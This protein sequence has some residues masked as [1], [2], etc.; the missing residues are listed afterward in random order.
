MVIRLGIWGSSNYQGSPGF[1]CVYCGK[2]FVHQPSLIRHRRKCE[3]NYYLSCPH[4]DRRFH[5]RDRYQEHLQKLLGSDMAIHLGIW[6]SSNYQGSPGFPCVYC[7]KTFV[8]QPSLIRH[9]RKC[10]GNYYLSCPHC[11][12]RF[13]R[14]DSYQEHLQM[15]YA[16]YA[17]L[18]RFM[19]VRC[20]RS[21]VHRTNLCRHR[22]KCEGNFHLSCPE[23]GQLFHRRD[24][25]KE[26]LEKKHSRLDCFVKP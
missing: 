18:G 19:C 8:H 7:G 13:H 15:Y 14:R 6:G 21:F 23:C 24:R 9:R 16:E 2:T 5:R 10:E 12:R 11:D 22:K 1:P 20:G 17:R 25:Y 3:G 26:H 4:C